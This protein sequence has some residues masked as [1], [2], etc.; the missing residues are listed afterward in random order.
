MEKTLLITGKDLPD[1]IDFA[2][3]ALMTGRNVVATTVDE[4]ETKKAADGGTV[5]VS[6][7]K[8]SPIS[9]RG[10]ILECENVY[11]KLDEA[12]IYFDE[13]YFA[14]KYNSISHE[15]ISR[16][17]DD[18]IS[19]LQYV[20]QEILSRYEKRPSLDPIAYGELKPAKLVFL[21]K[22]IPGEADILKNGSLR[23]SAAQAAGPLV[24]AAAGAFTAFAENI[25]AMYG[26]LGYLNI[27]LAKADSANELSKNDRNL[28]GWIC[29]YMNEVDELKNKLT[30]KQ[31]INW[32]KAGS[33]GPGGFALFK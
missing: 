32:V 7:N 24:K 20:T 16:I 12:I 25:A 31:S 5:T 19:A 2:D 4:G 27:I 18:L 1:G 23:N 14:S 26:N 21:L 22:Q 17:S 9:A 29:S 30:A 8:L 15:N 28:A 10:L 3:G 11:R 6:W 13:A 33:K